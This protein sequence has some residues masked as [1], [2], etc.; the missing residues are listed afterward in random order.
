LLTTSLAYN[1]RHAIFYY[2]ALHSFVCLLQDAKVVNDPWANGKHTI[3]PP[4]T[5]LTFNPFQPSP[6]VLLLTF[7]T[8]MLLSDSRYVNTT[9]LMS[10]LGFNS[11]ADAMPACVGLALVA[12]V[13]DGFIRG[14]QNAPPHWWEAKQ[15]AAA[16]LATPAVAEYGVGDSDGDW[17]EQVKLMGLAAVVSSSNNPPIE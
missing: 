13:V 5:R 12:F 9:A 16:G 17:W 7:A 3:P 10:S 15:K 4:S 2:L 1:V 14:F 11:L 8:A 6:K